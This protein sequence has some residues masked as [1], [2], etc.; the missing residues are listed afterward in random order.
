MNTNFNLEDIAI[1]SIEVVR[2]SVVDNGSSVVDN[3]SSLDN[4]SS[5]VDNGGSVDDGGSWGHRV[6]K[7]ILVQVL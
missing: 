1:A 3:W 2:R 6:N 5:V 4:W 7:A